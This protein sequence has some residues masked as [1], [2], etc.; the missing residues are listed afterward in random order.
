[1]ERSYRWM[2]GGYW[3]Y[4]D[5]LYLSIC[6]HMYI[7]IG[8]SLQWCNMSVMASQLTGNSTLCYLTTCSK[9]T[10]KIYQYSHCWPL[11][12]ESIGG[13]PLQRISNAE[14][15][16][17]LWRHN[18]LLLKQNS[19]QLKLCFRYYLVLDLLFGRDVFILIFTPQQ[20]RTT[21]GYF[22]HRHWQITNKFKYYLWLIYSVMCFND[23]WRYQFARVNNFCLL[24]LI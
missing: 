4:V 22:V 16:S 8:G 23:N 1:M 19:H 13:F 5:F 17:M 14:N 24:G 7:N 21:M 12:S 3:L 11:R 18:V 9:W 6:E 10:T 2:A 20:N 15:L